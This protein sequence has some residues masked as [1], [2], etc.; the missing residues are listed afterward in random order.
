MEGSPTAGLEEVSSVLQG[1]LV[2][3]IGRM[4][5]TDMQRITELGGKV[6]HMTSYHRHSVSPGDTD[7]LGSQGFQKA[8]KLKL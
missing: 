6:E 2:S 4:E 3:M 7:R 8:R 1:L 5:T